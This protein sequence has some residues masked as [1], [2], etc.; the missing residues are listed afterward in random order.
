MII[1]IDN[2]KI[3]RISLFFIL[4]LIKLDDGGAKGDFNLEGLSDLYGNREIANTKI[5]ITIP[6]ITGTISAVSS[7]LIIFVILRSSLKVSTTYHRIMIAISLNDIITSIAIALT[8]L[9]MPKPG[10][11]LFV[12]SYNFAGKRIG[13]IG[14]CTAQGYFTSVGTLISFTYY[15]SLWVYYLCTIRYKMEA[16][17]ISGQVEPYLHFISVTLPLILGILPL[18]KDLYNPLPDESWCTL[19]IHPLI[20]TQHPY[21]EFVECSRGSK[22]DMRVVEL[23][24]LAFGIVIILGFIITL[25]HMSLIFSTIFSEEKRF[26]AYESSICVD[27]SSSSATENDDALQSTKLKYEKTILIAKQ[28]LSYLLVWIFTWIFTL[29]NIFTNESEVMTALMMVFMPLQGFWSFIIFSYHKVYTIRRCR[30]DYSY[31][32]AFTL[33]FTSPN[34]PNI[35]VSNL[36]LVNNAV[37]EEEV[38]SEQQKKEK[39]SID[40]SGS[41]K[42]FVF[43]HDDVDTFEDNKDGVSNK[44]MNLSGFSVSS[45]DSSGF[46]SNNLSN[47]LSSNVGI[48]LA[49]SNSNN[50]DPYPE[51]LLSEAFTEE[52]HHKNPGASLDKVVV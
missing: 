25:I 2:G 49:G 9:P 5:G 50:T 29:L 42:K 35:L 51:E 41:N 10:D 27:R 1:S 33:I 24:R 48:S 18:A 36:S 19:T 22:D 23:L 31:F 52:E 40:I 45:V 46:L 39:D 20:C 11:D 8:T 44:S 4:V 17:T 3:S 37:V 7:S 13:N 34:Y 30:Q 32:K 16:V 28:C 47:N 43:A 26:K 38:A 12:D 14:T 21:D 6:R 15:V